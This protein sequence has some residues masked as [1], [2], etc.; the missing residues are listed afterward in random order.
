L[1]GT[2]REQIY[3]MMRIEPSIV[4]PLLRTAP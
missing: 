1:S 4:E 3:R 2:H